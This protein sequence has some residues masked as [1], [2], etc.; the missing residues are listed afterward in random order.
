[1]SEVITKEITDILGTCEQLVKDASETYDLLGPS[2]IQELV[3]I[4]V[5]GGQLIEELY[6]SNST[7]FRMF[8]SVR[9]SPT[10]SNMNE[11]NH[12]NLDKLLG[13][14][15]AVE[16]NIQSGMIADFRKL[17]QADIFAD[18]LEMAEYLHKEKY[19]DASAVLI[20]ATLEDSLRKL[21]DANGIPIHNS[22]GK[23]LTIDPLNV[24]LAKKNVYNALTQK[25][26]TSWASLRND[27]THGHFDKYDSDQVKQMLL[28]VQKF[29]DDYLK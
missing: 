13:I 7:F 9:K 16:S 3:S 2:R 1:M 11:Y 4:T 8:E 29:C 22:D 27:A 6:G 10:F 15:R 19:K 14:F 26:I 24:K 23:F 5:R 21:A 20:G 28:F 12:E 17:V 25:Q 18:F